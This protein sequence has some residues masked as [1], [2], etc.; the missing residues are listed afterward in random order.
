M[1]LLTKLRSYIL[2]VCSN[3]YPLTKR[4]SFAL[5]LVPSNKDE[6]KKCNIYFLNYLLVDF[7]LGESVYSEKNMPRAKCLSL[8]LDWNARTQEMTVHYISNSVY[9]LCSKSRVGRSFGSLKPE[10]T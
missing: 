5:E 3:C 8:L 7:L 2:I 4:Y 1:S 6:V 10:V 9:L